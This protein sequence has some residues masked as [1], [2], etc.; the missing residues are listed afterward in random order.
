MKR[1]W[2]LLLLCCSSPVVAYQINV[3]EMAAY[4]L[5]KERITTLMQALYAP[6]S[7]QPQIIILPSQRGLS[8]VNSGVYDA[9]AGRVDDV[10]TKY[11][12]LI[13]V[14]EP[15][16]NVSMA[17]FCIQERHCTLN[18]QQDLVTIRGSLIVS[19]YCQQR[20]F[21]C[22]PVSNEVSAFQALQKGHTQTLLADDLFTL[23]GI[24]QSGL[25]QLYMRRLQHNSYN[26]FHYVHQQHQQLV[27]QLNQAIQGMKKSGTIQAIFADIA[28]R[29]ADCQVNLTVLATD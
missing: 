19:Q 11:P 7:I 15:L 29:S 13:K 17:I 6:L 10:V 8:Y 28:N 4:Q 14:P 12:N 9:E 23:G 5:G 21:T 1:Y 16:T 25:K 18:P 24:C 3:S 26:I 2:I 20:G 27:P 22:H